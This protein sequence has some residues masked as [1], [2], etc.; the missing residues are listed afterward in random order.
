MDGMFE[1][2]TS[3][4]N[5][6]NIG[7]DISQVTDMTNML[8]DVVL[9]AS[10]YSD[11]LVKFAN[12]TVQT[13]VVFGDG[14]ST[15]NSTGEA[16]RNI[17]T[18]PPN[19]WTITDGGPRPVDMS[20]RSTW[21]TTNANTVITIPTNDQMTYDG[22]I[23]WGDGSGV[24][25]FTVYNDANLT[26]TYTNA[27]EYQVK[28]DGTFETFAANGSTTN[29][30]ITLLKS[31]ENLGDVGWRRFFN[32]FKGCTG[33]TS[34]NTGDTDW[35]DVISLYGCFEDCSSL[36][37]VTIANINGATMSN[38][39]NMEQMFKN[40][41]SLNTL[42]IINVDFSAI[43]RTKG[44]F[45]GT[46]NITSINLKGTTLPAD[47]NFDDFTRMH[48]NMT[49]CNISGIK[50]PGLS[51]NG[52]FSGCSSLQTVTID[53]HITDSIT[54][55]TSMFYN[56]TSL[57][58][59]PDITKI[60]TSNVTTMSHIFE[61]CSS[62]TSVN[63]D[64]IDLA[65]VTDF[66][67][68]FH[69]CTNISEISLTNLNLHNLTNLSGTFYNCTSLDKL[70]LS[71]TDFTSVDQIANTLGNVG[72]L[73]EV[74]L[75][76]TTLSSVDDNYRIF[77][78]Y[79]HSLETCDIRNLK[80]PGLSLSDMFYGC[81]NLVSVNI[82]G[83]TDPITNMRNT[84]GN[85]DSLQSLGN[86]GI[87]VTQVTDMRF[88]FNGTTLPVDVYSNFLIACADQSP[89]QYQT[90]LGAPSCKYNQSA[91]DARD[92]LF[93]E[94]NRWHMTDAGLE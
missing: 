8:D 90:E 19:N 34:F 9:P 6:G 28:I 32:S 57:N 58:T 21:E 3:L 47:V 45:L 1:N 40:C 12:Q 75:N 56:C 7:I 85:C 62:L 84:F 10:V 86:I 41:P 24:Q 69:D 76:G 22:T 68:A 4:Y 71:N 15:Y 79:R 35:V 55:M 46:D 36:E 70:D 74:I 50:V 27:G 48:T 20:F 2:C 30:S 89:L 83:I 53:N 38:V 13:G 64:N 91:V 92:I 88:I 26:H 5:L 63:I 49:H 82:D 37:T 67:Y 23:D 66:S 25:T 65:A 52:L 51:L 54:S 31:V 87:N 60:N 93:Q 44:L 11:M 59:M 43:E 18:N 17:L 72:V 94:P 42:N 78:Y 73:T 80:V 29:T 61:S 16:A 81:E 39:S 33:L 14:G 77:T